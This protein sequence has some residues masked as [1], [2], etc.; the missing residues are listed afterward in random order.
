[1]HVIL[2][3]CFSPLQSFDMVANSEKH[4]G[5]NYSYGV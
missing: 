1:M 5:N 3:F 2:P 4:N